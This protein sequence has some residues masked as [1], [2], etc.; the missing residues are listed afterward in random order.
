M[1]EADDSAGPGEAE[2]RV[3]G[4]IVRIEE[5]QANY[6]GLTYRAES[7]LREMGLGT[8]PAPS[9]VL[10]FGSVGYDDL[11]CPILPQDI[12]EI[13]YTE[14]TGVLGQFTSWTNYA[15]GKLAGEK[16]R[17]LLLKSQLAVVECA[18]LSIEREFHARTQA[19]AERIMQTYEQ[20][21]EL[22]VD[23]LFQQMVCT[24][25]EERAAAL[26]RSAKALSREL[27]R[28]AADIQN[29]G[30]GQ[31]TENRGGKRYGGSGR[32]NVNF[33]GDDD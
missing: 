1:A 3:K 18:I 20:H 9:T 27:S 19:D 17:L 12:S 4:R 8:I 2:F 13:P 7:K 10:K 16:C 24:E 11:G 6:E 22:T 21:I 23:V 30:L 32:R 33:P 14:I 28:Q 5:I 29:Q 26:A 15:S 25:L 31:N